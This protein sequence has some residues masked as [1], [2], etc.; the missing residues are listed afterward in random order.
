MALAA[1]A[2][3]VTIHAAGMIGLANTLL[4]S[5]RNPQR[6]FGPDLWLLIRLAWG[7]IAL[8]LVEI[9]VWAV[10]YV[11]KGC[12]PD[13][14]TAY[15][16]SSVT[17]TTVGYGDLVLSEEWRSMAAAEALTGILM[18]GLSTGF[19]FMVLN[20]LFGARLHLR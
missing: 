15:Y 6:R 19:F 4:G 1:L 20:R 17:Y 11:W 7:F 9:L 18:T 12:L 10:V 13:L 2:L 5:D 3:C 8:H 16:F 14:E